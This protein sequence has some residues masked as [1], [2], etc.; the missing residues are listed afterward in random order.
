MNILYLSSWYPYP[1]DNGSRLRAFHLLQGLA[2][3]HKVTVIAFTDTDQSPQPNDLADLAERVITLPRRTY[4]PGRMRALIGLVSPQPRSLIDTFDP[5]ALQI[6]Q[7]VVKEKF[8]AI[9]ASELSMAYYARVLPHR[10]KIFDEVEIGLY[11]DAYKSASGLARWRNGLTWFKYARFLRAMARDFRVLTAVS[12]QE[13]ARLTGIGIPPERIEIIPNGVDCALSDE[14]NCQ[15]EPFTLIYNGAL[16]YSANYDAMHF[17]L[18]EILPQVRA[19]EPRV[20]LKITG[21]APQFAINE[22]SQDNVV[23][24]TGYVQDIRALV[25]SSAVCIVPLRQGGGTRLK[26]LEAMALGTPVVSTGK[27]AEGL[28]LENNKELLVADS[29]EE[30]ARA[31]VRLL[32]DEPLRVRLSRAARERICREY[33]WRVIQSRMEQILTRIVGTE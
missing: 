3:K 18:E 31:I 4:Q 26:I 5:H 21:R 16:T 6:I 12:A 11:A 22:L 7:E 15:R 29:P 1:P 2:Q 27:G 23:S 20:K 9:V 13:R 19:L 10:A 25:K 24:F 28:G 14:D 30:F 17:F 8:D 32:T 33:D